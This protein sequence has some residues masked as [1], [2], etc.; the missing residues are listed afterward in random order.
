MTLPEPAPGMV[1]SYSYLWPDER[2]AGLE[3]GRKDRPCA[4]VVARL[5]EAG[6]TSVLVVPITHTPPAPDRHP[7]RL[8]LSIK[9]RLGLDEAPSWIVTDELTQF[10]C[11]G[12]DLRPISR[13]TPNRFDYGFLPVELFNAVK[14]AIRLNAATLRNVPR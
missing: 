11:P 4:I 5:D 14:R 13:Q 8:P 1:I 7:V 2:K 12:F 10:I 9:R 3:D 6:D